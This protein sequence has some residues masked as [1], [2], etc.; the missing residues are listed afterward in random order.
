MLT[1]DDAVQSYIDRIAAEHRPLFDR[2]HRLI[3]DAYPNSTVTLSY[4][5]PT[6]RVGDQRFHVGVWQHGVSMYGWR[7]ANEP[8]FLASHPALK[9]GRGTI[10]L[11]PADAEEITDDELR[12]VVRA[13]LG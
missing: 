9:H 2:L 7:A 6:Y 11:R 5:L 12:G 4:G 1:M 8:S 10:R 13:A 3:L